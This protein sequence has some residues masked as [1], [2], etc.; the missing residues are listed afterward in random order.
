MAENISLDCTARPVS[1]QSPNN[2]LDCYS[3]LR[4][5]NTSFPSALTS[6]QVPTVSFEYDNAGN[7][8]EMTDALGE[9]DYEY[10][11]LSQLTAETRDFTES[12]SPTDR[13]FRLEYTYSISGQ[14]K[15]LKDS[16]NDTIN[17]AHDKVGRLSTVTGSSFAGVTSYASS[18][19]YRAWGGLESLSYGNN[20]VM[21]L[22]FDERLRANH[23]QLVKNG[24]TTLMSKN[25]SFYADGALR[26]TDDLVDDKFDRVNTFDNIGRIKLAKS[27]LEARGETPNQQQLY[28]T[29]YRQTYTFNAFGNLT[30]RLHKHWGLND[31]DIDHDYT[32]NR[33][34]TT[35]LTPLYDADGRQTQVKE[36]SDTLQTTYDAAG[37]PTF[38]HRDLAPAGESEITRHYDGDGRAEARRTKLCRD[39][40]G[41]LAVGER[42]QPVLHQIDSSRRRGREPSW[43]RR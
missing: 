25:Y 34:T 42:G 10:N 8:I 12:F 20:T 17:Y 35:Y 32:N 28:D 40:T 29:P 37:R 6:R 24:T 43:Q 15:S 9:V 1:A 41:Y 11:S 14:L 27:S 33:L 4:L 38:F 13:V 31:Y 23:S 21:S 5:S 7:R 18:P 2:F 19:H 36:M 22:T 16:Y 3:L 39:R 30:D 26:K